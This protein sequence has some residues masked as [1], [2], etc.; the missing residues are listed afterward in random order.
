MKRR[1]LT[2]HGYLQRLG[3]QYHWHNAGYA[4]FDDFLGALS[5]RKRKAI[6]KERAQVAAQGLGIRTL[7]GDDLTPA[8]WDAFYTF[9]IDTG[10]RKWGSPYLTRPFFDALHQTMRD[11]VVLIM[12]FRDGAPIAGALNLRGRDAL[13]GRNWGCIEDVPYLHFECCYYRAIDYA[14]EHKLARVEAGAQGEHKIQRG[15]LPVITY[16]AH[17]IA[18][19]RLERAVA[20]FLRRERPAVAA[21]AEALAATGPYRRDGG[22]GRQEER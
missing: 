16:S 11:R 18:D 2:E 5:S 22:P 20:D 12:A 13:Y 1:R 9:Y 19:P 14:I 10:G 21:E 8:H 15:Y 4:S 7:S 17:W 3:C 6:R